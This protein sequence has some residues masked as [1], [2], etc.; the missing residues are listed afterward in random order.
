M[1]KIIFYGCLALNLTFAVINFH[2]GSYV[3]GFVSLG[4]FGWMLYQL[5][6]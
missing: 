6:R 5:F 1:N 4:L 2:Q 3:W